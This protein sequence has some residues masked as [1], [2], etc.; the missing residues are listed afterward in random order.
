[1]RCRGYLRLDGI[2][3]GIADLKVIIIRWQFSVAASIRVEQKDCKFVG[4]QVK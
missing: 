2:Q 1:M 3:V 4:Q